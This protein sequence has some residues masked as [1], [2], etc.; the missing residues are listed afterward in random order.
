MFKVSNNLEIRPAHDLK[1][2]IHADLKLPNDHRGRYNAPT[3]DEVAVFLVDEDKGPRDIIL[4]TR[5]GQLQR[6]SELHRL[7]AQYNIFWFF[8]EKMMGTASTFHNKTVVLPDL[9]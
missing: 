4:N 6:V 7:Y 3:V 2:I 9:R 1:L 8:H 5:D